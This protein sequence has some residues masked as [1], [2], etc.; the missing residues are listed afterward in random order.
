MALTSPGT[1]IFS[2]KMIYF[3]KKF[4]DTRKGV[5]HLPQ[6]VLQNK[7]ELLSLKLPSGPPFNIIK[8]QLVCNPLSVLSILE[9][10]SFLVY[11]CLFN[12]GQ[13]V[14]LENNQ[15]QLSKGYAWLGSPRG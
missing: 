10:D 14:T 11:K 6:I 3:G 8:V 13:S 1:Q 15:C 7:G 9:I 2:L 4:S 5:V 12:K